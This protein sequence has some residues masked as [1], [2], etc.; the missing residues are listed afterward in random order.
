MRYASLVLGTLLI[1]SPGAAAAGDAPQGVRVSDA[2]HKAQGP[3]IALGPDGAVYIV[4]IDEDAA[5]K[6]VDPQHG[7]SHMAATNLMFA[8]S[9]DGGRSFSEPV[10]V[11]SKPGE[12]WGFT[13]SKPRITVGAN[14]TLHVFYPGNDVNPGNGKPE[15]VALYTRSTDQGRSF[16]APQRLNTMASTDASHLVHGGLTHAHVFGT[17]AVD[18]KAQ[19]YALWTDT[20]DMTRESD[21]AKVFMAVSRDDGQSFGKDAEVF[22]GDVCPCCQLTA[23][24][25]SRDRLF[26]G[27]RQVEGTLRDSTV[28]MSTDGGRNF[29]ARQRIVG[30]QR[31]SIEG[32]PLKPTSVAAEGGNLYATYFS[33]GESPAGAYFVRS[34]DGGANWSAPMLAHPGA[35]TSDAPVVALAGG[36]LHLFWH[37]KVGDGPRRLYTRASTDGGAGF[38]PVTE[39]PAPPGAAQLPVVAG[40]PDG[41]V[42]LAWQQGTEIRSMAWR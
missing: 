39:I 17:I 7:H 19:V 35:L 20:R 3:E 21:F 16:S 15:A 12:V 28:A 31:W 41:S 10:Q 36:T 42:Q 6:A 5:P 25:D 9:T 29:S 33:G 38:G 37:A 23:F 24:V 30:E 11:N 18:R 40:R 32:C 14:G 8:R 13:V 26:I 4:W 22:P 2:G 34:T 1:L 27:S